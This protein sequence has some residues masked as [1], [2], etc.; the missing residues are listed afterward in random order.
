MNI[1][2]LRDYGMLDGEQLTRLWAEIDRLRQIEAFA[3]LLIAQKG[4]YH[5]EIAYKRLAS[6][7]TPNV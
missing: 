1:D 7:L 6:V 3:K 5:T 2:H 4:R